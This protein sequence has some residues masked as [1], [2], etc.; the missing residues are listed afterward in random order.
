[1]DLKKGVEHKEVIFCK[2]GKRSWKWAGRAVLQLAE[3]C[4]G[5]EKGAEHE[6]VIC[7]KRGKR[8]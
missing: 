6:G 7:C 3:S 8:G 2:R 1:M 5:L 4:M